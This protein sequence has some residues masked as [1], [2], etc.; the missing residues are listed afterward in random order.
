M[1]FSEAKNILVVR[2]DA[3]GDVILSEPVARILKGHYQQCRVTYA[4]SKYAA[5]VLFNN[6]YIDR[7][8]RLPKRDLSFGY[9]NIK[10]VARIFAIDGYDTAIILRPTLFNALSVYF[11]RI[12]IRIGTANRLYSIF[13]NKRIKEH[14]S[15]N[16]KSEMFY[17]ISMLTPLR[18]ELPETDSDDIRP[19]LYPQKE[20]LEKGK[21]LLFKNGVTDADI[22]L[23]IH[24][25]GRGS[26]P[27]WDFNRFVA[28]IGQL[29]QLENLKI[30]ITGTPEEY[31]QEQ[32]ASLKRLVTTEGGKVINFIGKTDLSMLISLIKLSD[33]VITNSTGTAHISAAVETPLIGIY[34]DTPKH[35]LRRWAPQGIA[36]KINIISASDLGKIKPEKVFKAC[37]NFIKKSSRAKT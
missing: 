30:V 4:V 17:N 3:I 33:L 31:D 10:K 8:I 20:Q 37:I 21:G 9:S 22:P 34:P 12:P 35:S 5:P 32:L 36:D 2:T 13:F 25:G 19:K 14:R 29:C 1:P 11:S 27:R 23:I 6:P 28:L 16:K 18:I 26:A 15:E 24:P 7:V